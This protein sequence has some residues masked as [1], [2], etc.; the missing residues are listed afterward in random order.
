MLDQVPG[1]VASFTA[2]GAYDQ[3]GVAAAVAERCPDAAIIVPP[4]SS[5]VPS[6]TAATAPTQRDRHL[7][8]IAEHGR[9]A[10]Q[11]T[12]GY[13]KRARAEAAMGRFKQVIGDGLRART[14][15]RRTTEVDVAVHALNRMMELGRPI[16]VRIA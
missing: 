4:R 2:D 8:S 15:E 14:D 16:S 11:K 10:W 5:T 3:E 9:A 12:S 6:E 13:T 1:P 7:H